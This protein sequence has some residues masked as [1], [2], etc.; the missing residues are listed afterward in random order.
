MQICTLTQTQ[1]RQHPTTQFFTGWMP[2]LP[3]NQQHQS[4]EGKFWGIIN[5]FQKLEKVMWTWPLPLKGLCV[6]QR[7]IFHMIHQ[8]TKFEVYLKPFK[9]TFK[10]TKNLKGITWRGHAPFRDNLS[11]VGWDLLWSTCTPNL[12]SLHSPTT[13]AMQKVE[14]GVV[15]ELVVTQSHCQCHY[16]IQCNMASYSTLIETMCLVPFSSYSELFFK[17]CQF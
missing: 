16:S 14:I 17:G 11:S 3:P 7:L 9:K 12:K 5:Y 13:K 1:P 2:F 15:W 6:I 8:C 10:G 4:T